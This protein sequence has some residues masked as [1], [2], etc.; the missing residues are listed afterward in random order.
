MTG[1]AE[2]KQAGA[3]SKKDAEEL[4]DAAIGIGLCIFCGNFLAALILAAAL[5]IAAL[6]LA[7]ALILM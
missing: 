1:C 5:I 7:A 3:T 6:I 4:T 2:E